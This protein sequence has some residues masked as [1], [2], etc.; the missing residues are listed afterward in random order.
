MAARDCLPSF[1]SGTLL[2]GDKY[3]FVTEASQLGFWSIDQVFSRYRNY[4]GEKD[5]PLTEREKTHLNL[6]MDEA[7]IVVDKFSES[8]P[9]QTRWQTRIRE[10]FEGSQ[11]SV[12]A[13]LGPGAGQPGDPGSRCRR[14]DHAGRQAGHGRSGAARR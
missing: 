1:R 8:D 11:V 13:T 2:H 14:R 10:G 3:V 6:L 12:V 7:T 9:E 5:R 4:E